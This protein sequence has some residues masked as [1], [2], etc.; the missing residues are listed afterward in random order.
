MPAKYS[1]NSRYV[2]LSV[3]HSLFGVSVADPF[4][5]VLVIRFSTVEMGIALE[6]KSTRCEDCNQYPGQNQHGYDR[7]T[8][9]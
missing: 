6:S 9:K 5:I 3:C 4:W 1:G 8:D 7:D 2:V